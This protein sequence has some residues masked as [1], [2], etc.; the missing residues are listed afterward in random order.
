MEAPQSSADN[1]GAYVLRDLMRDV[2][3][4]ADGGDEHIYITCVEAWGL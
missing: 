4:S 2:P 1:N 3:L